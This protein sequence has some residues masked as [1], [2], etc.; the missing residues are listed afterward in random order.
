M[1]KDALNVSFKT[2]KEIA[3][4]LGISTRTLR[5]WL[6]QKG[7]ELPRTLLGPKEQK[8]IYD[9]VGKPDSKS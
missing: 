8:I 9:A 1:K 6:K 7:I 4:E 3:E 2:R 5:R